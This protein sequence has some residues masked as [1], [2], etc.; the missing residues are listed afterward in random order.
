MSLL[1]AVIIY[2]NTLKLGEAVAGLSATGSPIPLNL[3]SHVSQLGWGIS[4]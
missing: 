2:W 1:A 4:T 3:L